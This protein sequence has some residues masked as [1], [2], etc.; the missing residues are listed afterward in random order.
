MLYVISDTH[1]NDD[2]ILRAVDLIAQGRPSRV[3]HCGDI[4]SPATLELFKG[5]P[6]SL[7][8]GNNDTNKTGL[9][10]KAAALG[11]KIADELKFRYL[12]KSFL[13]YHGTKRAV[14]EKHI[15]SQFFDY[16]LTGH[17]HER[18]N[19]KIGRTR[20]INPGGLYAAADYSIAA[21]DVRKDEV[22]FIPVAKS[23]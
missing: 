3:V 15:D 12:R 13:V 10:R 21:L 1:D 5:L 14:L 19:E 17:T 22:K 6:L 11:F 18:R 20:V 7:A 16:I 8:Y 4:C 2:A 23:Y 9:Q